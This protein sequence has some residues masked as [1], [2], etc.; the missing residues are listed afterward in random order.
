MTQRIQR[1]KQNFHTP[2]GES[3]ADKIVEEA[4][5]YFFH[6]CLI[7]TQCCVKQIVM[8]VFA[9]WEKLYIREYKATLTA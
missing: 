5:R 1:S 4:E 6:D 9:G 8:L 3:A 7:S 2:S